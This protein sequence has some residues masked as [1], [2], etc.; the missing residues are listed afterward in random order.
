VSQVET[1]SVLI[2]DLVGSTSLASRI[3]PTA[4]DEL[5]REH[6]AVLR[7]AIAQT[8]GREVK[9][10]GDGLMVAFSS[11]LGAVGCGVAMQQRID[12]RNRGSDEQ[13]SV[14]VGV[15]LG[16]ATAEQDDYFGMPVVEASRLCSAAKGGQILASELVRM[17]LGSRDEHDFTPVGALDLKGLPDGFPAFEVSWEP[18]AAERAGLPVPARLREVPHASYVG[19][20]S[21]RERL[22]ALW[23]ESSAGRRRVVLLSGEPGIGKTR[24]ATHFALSA[25]SDEHATILYGRCEE[26]LS[27]PYQPWLEALRHYVEHGP[28]AV[29]SAHVGRHGG[30]LGRL[31]PGLQ[32]RVPELPAPRES[33]PETERYLLF[34]AV[35]GLLEAAAAEAPV[36]LVLDDLH[37][38][39]KPTLQ[40]MRHVVGTAPAI[41]LLLVGAYRESDIGRGHPLAE[42]LA[43]LRREDGVERIALGGLAQPEVVEIM[44]AAAGHELDDTG[45]GLAHEIARETDGNPFFVAELLRHLVES[46]SLVRQPDG[47][48]QLAGGLADLGLPESVREVIGRRVHR[49]GDPAQRV[50]RVASVIGREFDL[51]LLGRVTESEEDDLLDLL[52]EALA[53]SVITES[54]GELGRFSFAHALINHT[55]YEA[56]GQTRRARLHGRVAAALEEICGDDTGPRVCELARHWSAATAPVEAGK[57]VE[58]SCRAGQNALDELA[59][60]DAMGWFAHALEL[61]ERQPDPDPH[62]RCELLIGL[63]DAQ[64]QAGEAA[65]RETL[66]EACRLARDLGDAE[67]LARGALANNRGYV[68]SY[69]DVDE[70]RIEMLRASLDAL[71]GREDETRARLLG[72]LALELT[73]AADLP[74]RQRLSDE[75]LGLARRAGDARTL[76]FLLPRRVTDFAPETVEERVADA[77]ELVGLAGDLD[78]PVASFHAWLSLFTVSLPINQMEEADRALE[79][80][81]E[82]ADRIR[83]PTLL[84]MTLFSGSLRARL[85]GRL[86]EAEKLAEQAV[87][88]G[89]PDAL[90]LYTGQ[91]FFIRYDQ[92]RLDE[93]EDLM[94]AAVEDNPGIPGFAAGLAL[95][96]CELGREERARELLERYSAHDFTDFPRDVIWATGLT[97]FS[98]VAAR[99]GDRG[100][101]TALYEQL[102]PWGEQIATN[103]ATSEGSVA[104]YLGLLAAALGREDDFDEHFAAGQR[105][106]ERHGAPIYVAR[107]QVD[108]AEALLARDR[109]DDAQRAR[110]LLARAK[111]GAREL[112]AENVRARAE[113]LLAGSGARAGA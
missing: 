71:A 54:A 33:D 1:I 99:L 16:D 97:L 45:L 32:A 65:F 18:L 7:E 77:R 8:G 40:L 25:R 39:D 35:T 57:A 90:T 24:L 3:G 95:L 85:A 109:R 89:E 46:D 67:R 108:W 56:L 59:P 38:A 103:A 110:S 81:R 55:L 42:L 41:R 69:G 19:R 113:D 34:G 68:S 26:D 78:D 70:E 29:L 47:R 64:R 31:V 58:Y 82:L 15:S 14:R 73:F 44:E 17:M 13:L 49:L 83:Q 12:R 101:A 21:E 2:T 22:E 111:V 79:H 6:F 91:L 98:E 107:T 28:D 76:A 87:E 92:G 94:V 100:A 86:D 5:R 51:E 93:L 75:A 36:V 9:N 37:W 72:L 30:E 10:L 63:G 53:A 23:C 48:W 43:D 27:A 50:L 20:A 88:T 112:G 11:A 52:E 106:N 4:A 104:R 60:D 66:L 61:Y 105:A 96:F 102:R 80:M 74:E 62:Q 84:W